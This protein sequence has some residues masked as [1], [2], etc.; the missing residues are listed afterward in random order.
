M[1]W[2]PSRGIS[3]EI[4]EAV[5]LGVGRHNLCFDVHRVDVSMRAPCGSLETFT[6]GDDA[7]RKARYIAR[8]LPWACDPEFLA[9][10]EDLGERLA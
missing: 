8:E 3:A 7:L 1:G 6:A 5:C 9:V 10:F 4:D 2:F